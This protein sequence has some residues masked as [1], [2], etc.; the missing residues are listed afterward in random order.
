MW[1]CSKLKGLNQ[2]QMSRDGYMPPI[3]RFRGSYRTFLLT[4]ERMK[5]GQRKQGVR[6][7]FGQGSIK[8][9]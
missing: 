1:P 2:A 5:A 7:E 6:T 4:M 8:S 9:E 3:S